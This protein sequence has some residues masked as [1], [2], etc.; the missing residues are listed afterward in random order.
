LGQRPHLA[1]SACVPGLGEY[2]TIL[3]LL[4]SLI[5]VRVRVDLRPLYGQMPEASSKPATPTART[6]T[7]S[8]GNAA[9]NGIRADP[10][11]IHGRPDGEGRGARSLPAFLR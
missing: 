10:S 2:L 7:G 8:A 4:A 9:G 11:P 5:A 1:Q 6:A 3:Q